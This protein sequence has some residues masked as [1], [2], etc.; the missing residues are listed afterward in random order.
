[1]R[2]LLLLLCVALLVSSARGQSIKMTIP[3]VT[4]TAG[5]EVIAFETSDTTSTGI[6]GGGIA[7]GLPR[8]ELVKLKK[9]KDSST[10][11]LFSYST[12]GS[13]MQQVRFDFYDGNGS[14]TYRI[15]L[16][17]VVVAHFSYLVPEC[18]GCTKMYH[19]VWFDYLKI[20]VN[21]PATGSA[22]SYNRATRVS[23]K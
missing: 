6:S 12:Q 5:E 2:Q 10:N 4:A 14:I 20:Q 22:V 16:E 11:K 19:Q 13:H 21:D 7:T 1:M 3:G 18:A 17:D 23:A 15:T 9:L 8:F